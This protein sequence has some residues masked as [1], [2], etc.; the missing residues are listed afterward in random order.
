MSLCARRGQRPGGGRDAG[1]LCAREAGA[2]ALPEVVQAQKTVNRAIAT[3]EG[4]QMSAR[5]ARSR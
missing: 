3:S 2:G 5:R 4:D 1:R